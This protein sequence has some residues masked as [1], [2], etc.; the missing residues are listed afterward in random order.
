MGAGQFFRN[1]GDRVDS[2]GRNF[3]DMLANQAEE[4]AN[5][6]R[7]RAIEDIK[8]DMQANAMDPAVLQAVGGYAPA[9]GNY[10][11]AA[12][13]ERNSYSGL[14]TPIESINR[15]MNESDAARY[16]IG[17]AAVVGSGVAMTAGA[18]KLASIMGLLQEAQ[19]VEVA[20]DNELHS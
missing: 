8:A 10:L 15:A 6:A 14:Q 11:D 17:G 7:M 12:I 20:R 13:A 5:N 19:E 4:R 18:Q 2:A 1:M 3:D 9:G 16:G